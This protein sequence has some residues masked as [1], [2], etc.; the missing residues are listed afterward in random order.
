MLKSVSFCLIPFSLPYGIG[1]L[2]LHASF[3]FKRKCEIHKSIWQ[4]PNFVKTN[5]KYFYNEFY[6]FLL[7]STCLVNGSSLAPRCLA[8]TN[9]FC[10]HEYQSR[11]IFFSSF[12]K[13][14]KREKGKVNGMNGLVSCPFLFLKKIKMKFRYRITKRR[15]TIT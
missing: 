12:I 4:Y 7:G 5:R 9:K 14:K 10:Q 2:E 13:F 6:D 3:L 8:C 1:F 11:L 15:K